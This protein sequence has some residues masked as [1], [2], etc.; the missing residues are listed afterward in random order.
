MVGADEGF[1]PKTRICVENA[2][3]Q[4]PKTNGNLDVFT[5]TN[6][7][8]SPEA[9]NKIKWRRLELVSVERPRDRNTWL[10]I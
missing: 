3:I 10:D 2:N 5:D 8:G 1:P 9:E 4:P 7:T 6:W